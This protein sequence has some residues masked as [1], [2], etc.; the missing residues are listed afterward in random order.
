M[1]DFKYQKRHILCLEVVIKINSNKIAENLKRLRG[2]KSQGEVADSLGISKSA[3]SAYECGERIPRD[4]IKK[5][6]AD[7]YSRTVQEIFFD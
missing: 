7:F 5:K 1:V 3:V 4:E 2:D 6:I